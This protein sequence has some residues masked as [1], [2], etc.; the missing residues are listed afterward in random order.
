MKKR[1]FLPTGRKDQVKIYAT[2]TTSGGWKEKKEKTNNNSIQMS[3][4]P[5]IL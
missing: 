2:T 5:G 3:K 1:D 4:M